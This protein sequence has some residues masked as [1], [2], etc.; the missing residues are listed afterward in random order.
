MILRREV[1]RREAS[2]SSALSIAAVGLVI[3]GLAAGAGGSGGGSGSNILPEPSKPPRISPPNTPDNPASWRS[4]EFN[5]QDGLARIGVEHRYAAGATGQGTLGAIYDSGI[6]LNHPDVGGIRRDLSH[7]YENVPNDLTDTE[8]HGTFVYGIAGAR[9]NGVGIHGVAPNAEFMILRVNEEALRN[10]FADALRRAIDAGA[11]AMNNSWGNPEISIT[12]VPSSSELRDFLGS[13][14]IQQIEATAPADLS[15][16][17]ST[18]NGSKRQPQV[19][20]GLPYFIPEIEGNWIAVTA[21]DA[22]GDIR[23]ARL[24]DYANGCGVAAE[25]CLA[26]PGTRIRSLDAGGT[27][28]VKNGTSFAA[29]HVTGAVLILKSQFPELTTSEVHNILFDTAVDLGAPGVDSE[30]GQGA[31]NLNEALA[32]QGAF[33]VELG[34]QVNQKAIPLAKSW[35]VE[36]SVTGGALTEAL[37]GQGMLVTDRYDRG[38]TAQMQHRVAPPST[39]VSSDS[40]VGL[41]AAFSHHLEHPTGDEQRVSAPFDLRFDA[42]GTGHDVTRIAHVDPIMALANRSAGRAFSM[43]APVGDMTLS[44]ASS[45]GDGTALS[46]GLTREVEDGHRISMT[47]GQYDEESGFLGATGFGAFGTMQARTLYGRVQADIK[48]GARMMLN[49]SAT[50]GQTR[51]WSDTM[52]KRGRADTLAMAFGVTASDAFATGDNLSFALARPL[53]IQGGDMIVRAGA[54]IS[55][56]AEGRRTNAVRLAET[57]VPFG[58]GARATEFHLG[59]L[60]RFEIGHRPVALGLGAIARLDGGPKMDAAQIALTFRF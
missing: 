24:A 42:F 52:L 48:L 31:L 3:G 34:A 49:A 17:F 4:P 27:L 18:G 60:R 23:T 6:D 9:R 28:D 51:F 57:R 36:S 8:G 41:A 33:M 2:R 56:A 25:W 59:Y 35:M 5:R 22:T 30:F 58:K 40:Q 37:Q 7:S 50:A 13:A 12:D 15:V 32:P 55:A 26:A 53:S 46:V 16:V 39:R 43:S 20:S 44:L 11:D 47:L 19:F 1:E 54:G 10:Q 38:Y 45:T 29:P 21:L 14:L